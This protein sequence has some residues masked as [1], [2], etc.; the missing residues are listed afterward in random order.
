MK[1]LILLCIV[2]VAGYAQAQLTNITITHGIDNPTRIAVVPFNYAGPKLTDDIPDIIRND[3]NFSGQFESI[4][5]DKMLTFPQQESE[6]HYRDWKMINAEFLLIGSI[7]PQA[8]KY[9][10]TF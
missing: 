6:I 5:E 1:R 8:G 2:F 10:A 4:H 7:T 3:L 9:V